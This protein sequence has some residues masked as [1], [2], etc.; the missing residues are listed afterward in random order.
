METP[1]IR[2]K[3]GIS[4]IWI[5]PLVALSIGVWI[6]YTSY[7]DAGISIT[8]HYDNAE[9]ITPGKTQ[10]M[11]KGVP[12]GL[13][14]H[15]MVD[16]DLQGVTLTVKMEKKAKRGLVKDTKFWI[17]KPEISAG[18]ISGLAT[19]LTGSYIAIQPG[20]STDFTDS[21]E[22]LPEP[23]IIQP[24]SPGL[25]ITL[26]SDALNSLQKGSPVYTRNLQIGIVKS[27][28]LTDDHYILIDLFIEPEFSHLIKTGT[29]FWNSSGINFE[30][31]LQAGFS[32]KMESLASLI[33][34]GIS[35]GTPESLIDT[36]PA[37]TNGM[38]YKLYNSFDAAE[39]GLEMTL[40]LSSGGG[41][42][43]GKT[44]I[45]YRGLEAG[46][47]KKITLNNDA[48]HTV[49]AEIL[50]DPRAEPIL[51]KGSRFWVIRPEVSIDGV[52]NLEAI[53][54]GPYI[55]FQPG[56][57][58][59]Q[60]HFVVE[61]GKMPRQVLR[62]GKHFTLISPDSG[63]LEAGAPVLYKKITVGEVMGITFGPD[64]ES[65]QTRILIYDEY[66][67]LV[68]KDT[69]FWNVS[70]IE[71]DASLSHFNVNLSSL[72]S[73]LAGGI[74]FVNPQQE[75]GKISR[76]AEEGSSFTLFASFVKAVKNTPNL[77]PRGT[78]LQL[79]SSSDNDFDIGSPVLYKR[80]P[81][82]E[83]LD[84]SLSEDKQGIVFTVLIQEKYSGL[85]NSSTR[86]YNFSGFNINADLS[87]IEVQAGPIATIVNGG[88]SFMT[89][90]DGEPVH[91]NL[92]F[93]LYENYDAALHKDSIPITIRLGSAA[94]VKEKTKISYQGIQIGSVTRVDFSPD[95]Q[96]I[97]AETRVR[98]EAEKLFRQNTLLRLVKPEISLSGVRHLETVL[99]GPYIDI[100]PGDGELRTVFSLLHD[101]P[102]PDEYG[103]LKIVLETPRLGSLNIKSPVYYR[104]VQIGEVT[105]FA[106]SPTA[107]QVWV[108]VNI[109]PSYAN[110][111]RSGT[112][113]WSVSGIR[114]SWGLFS[115]FN[116][117]TE[118]MEAVV[119]G[120]ISLATPDGEEMG[121]PA[122]NGDHFILH[123]ENEQSWLDWNPLIMLNE[124]MQFTGQAR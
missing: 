100:I 28:H 87:G 88:I 62:S 12:V 8:I 47:V 114:A 101:I 19:I 108:N 1:I 22:G 56:D 98:K 6:L 118:S 72:K 7:R 60:D 59:Y 113:F 84:F 86:F 31:N 96:T 42:I 51:K 69:V 44:K 46:V 9:G 117:D 16:E 91:D 93:I 73:V 103:G 52:K 79:L 40:Q 37:A 57:G 67:D 41:I 99:T 45:M 77:R 123:E 74:A 38:V 20:T 48:N 106:L 70:G 61:E 116:L 10:V 49:N 3:R 29:R 30:G 14:E 25:H 122:V 90:G 94:G 21:F 68:R 34:G 23:P 120:G 13:V 102:E 119:A 121:E 66:S 65:I 5:L 50:L 35:C 55:T 63:F 115:G 110:L 33:Y 71:V 17:V 11:Y 18:R 85:I 24:D 43:E 89:P 92:T 97:M 64:A 27:Y 53:I 4:P 78:I 81:V 111:V 82:G 39:Y 107:Q 54:T 112:R 109:Q 36:S 105:G 124:E 80:I 104:Q 75:A 58:E 26:K 2:K 32:L 83:I 76:A 15:I 95:M